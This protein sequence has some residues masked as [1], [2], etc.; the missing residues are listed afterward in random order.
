MVTFLRKSLILSSLPISRYADSGKNFF[1]DL[2]YDNYISTANENERCVVDDINI[3]LK[4]INDI[5]T[6]IKV[7]SCNAYECLLWGIRILNNENVTFDISMLMNLMIIT[8]KISI[9]I[10]RIAIIIMVI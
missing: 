8:T 1:L 9:Y 7:D 2:L 6:H 4:Q 5:A 10:K 3:L